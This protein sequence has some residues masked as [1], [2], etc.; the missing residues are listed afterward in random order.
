MSWWP[1]T[2]Y[3]ILFRVDPCIV[4]KPNACELTNIPPV[5]HICVGE[6]GQHYFRQFNGL[7][8]VQLQAVIW[9]N[10]DLLSIGHLI[11]NF[12]EIRIQIRRFS[13][14]KTHLKISSAK[15]RPFCSGEDETD[16]KVVANMNLEQTRR[17]CCFYDIINTRQSRFSNTFYLPIEKVNTTLWVLNFPWLMTL[18]LVL[19]WQN[20]ITPTCYV[21]H[22]ID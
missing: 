8:P 9:T 11:T 21:I 18:A 3:C 2:S 13:F 10:A 5:P 19:S 16:C 1:Q 14:K 22:P 4:Y 6:L 17:Q 7:S 12:R 15:W 20:M